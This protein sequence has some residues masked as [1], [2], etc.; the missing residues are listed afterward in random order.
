M[1]ILAVETA[2][3]LQ[4]IALLREDQVLA[5][6]SQ[7][8]KGSHTKILVP[9]IHEVLS[10]QSLKPS[11]LNGLAV[12]IGPGSFSGLRVGLATVT[13][14]RMALEIP[15]VTVPT[16]EA[17]AWNLRGEKLPIC[18]ILKAR[19]GIVYWACFRWEG[20]KLVQL[21]PEQI[22]P[23]DALVQSLSETTVVF[24]EGW[25]LNRDA[26]LKM[27][28]RMKEAHREAMNASAVSVGLASLARFKTGK[29]AGYGA[30]PHY[31]QPSYAEMK[32]G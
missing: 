18:P 20:E 17:M 3:S 7:E 27:T 9:A 6:F 4:S 22:G 32:S 31:I 1:D 11:D 16:L 13:G 5:H 29:F 23:L 14:F 12:S 8:A 26:L 10:S 19:P 15:L 2:T 24:G 30:G 28:G 21:V 25:M